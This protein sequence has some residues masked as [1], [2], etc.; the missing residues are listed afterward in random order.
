MGCRLLVLMILLSAGG[1]GLVFYD[2]LAGSSDGGTE[3]VDSAQPDADTIDAPPLEPLQL[4]FGEDGVSG[5][6][7]GVTTDTVLNGGLP[8]QP[9]GDNPSFTAEE[10]GPIHGLLRFDLSSIPTTATVVG[11]ELE[12]WTNF[13]PSQGGTAELFR[14]A[15]EWD[16]ATATWNERSTGVAWTVAGGTTTGEAVGSI[17][18]TNDMFFESLETRIELPVALVAGWVAEPASNHGLIF[19]PTSGFV[20]LLSSEAVLIENA[21]ILHVSIAQ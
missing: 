8:D 3:Q 12:V 6:V 11:A 14:V 13:S 4:T 10:V 7:S 9:N 1:C 17:T 20:G 19:V 18:T 5:R 15:E 21:P 16:E 2:P